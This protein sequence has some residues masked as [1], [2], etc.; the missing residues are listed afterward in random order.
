[1]DDA[2]GGSGTTVNCTP[3]E[4]VTAREQERRIR[5]VLSFFCLFF[6]S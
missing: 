4:T 5:F 3:G 2:P 6:D 1:M